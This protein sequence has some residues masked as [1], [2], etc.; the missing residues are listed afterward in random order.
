MFSLCRPTTASESWDSPTQKLSSNQQQTTHYRQ[1]WQTSPICELEL[2]IIIYEDFNLADLVNVSTT[3]PQNHAAAQIL[4]RQTYAMTKFEISTRNSDQKYAR[5]ANNTVLYSFEFSVGILRY[6]GHLISALSINYMTFNA[7]ECEQLNEHINKYCR[8]SLKHFEISSSKG[9]EF[10]L[11]RG[12]FAGVEYL[13]FQ[14][15]KHC[16]SILCISCYET[17]FL[18]EEFV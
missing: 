9:S 5:I 6:F 18:W 11:L 14:N 2:L 17:A 12:P 8:E 7:S 13:R 10:K 1:N 4:F 15:Y 3:H 16:K